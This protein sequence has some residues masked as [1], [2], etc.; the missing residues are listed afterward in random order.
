MV[1]KKPGEKSEKKNLL[2]T[3]SINQQRKFLDKQ[4]QYSKLPT[5][6]IRKMLCLVHYHMEVIA[7]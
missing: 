1:S 3:G 5:S 4:S 7:G 6:R 2:C